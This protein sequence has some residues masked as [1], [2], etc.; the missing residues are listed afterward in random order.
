[1]LELIKKASKHILS[2]LILIGL[3]LLLIIPVL[4]Q[5]IVR[6]FQEYVNY[7]KGKETNYP[8]V[9]TKEFV[10][11][12]KGLIKDF[13]ALKTWQQIVSICAIIAVFTI[14]KWKFDKLNNIQS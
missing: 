9:F 3:I 6:Y 5:L 1:M 11:E 7:F 2:A 8:K 10:S 13:F 4:F 14:M 12:T